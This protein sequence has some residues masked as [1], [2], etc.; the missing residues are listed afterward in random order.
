VVV[1]R[2]F[3]NVPARLKFLKSHTAESGAIKTVL[4]ALALANEKTQFRISSQGELQ[5]LWAPSTR[6]AR[7]RE[8]LEV[9]ILYET[10]GQLE[11]VHVHAVYS[12]PHTVTRTSRQIWIFVQGRWVQDR[13]IQAAIMEAYRNLLMHGEYPLAAIWVDLP[14]DRVDV[15]IH[16]AKSQVKFVDSSLVF[17][18]VRRTIRNALETAPWLK[19]VAT[20]TPVTTD[21]SGAPAPNLLTPNPTAPNSLAPNSFA[22]CPESP[23]APPSAQTTFLPARESGTH[24][25]TKSSGPRLTLEDLRQA[26][27]LRPAVVVPGSTDLARELAPEK[28]P[29]ATF[30]TSPDN[31]ILKW[32]ALQV[33]GQ[34]NLTYIVAQA[35][36]RMYLVD[37]HAA[38]ERVVFES[39]MDRWR[40]GR[41]ERQGLLLP[42][43]FDLRPEQVEALVRRAADFERMGIEMEQTGLQSVAVKSFPSLLKEA[44]LIQE[45]PKLAEDLCEIDQDLSLERMVRDLFATMACHSVVRAGQ[46]L[47]NDEMKNLLQQM[48]QFPLSGFCPHGRPVYIEQTFRQLEKQFGRTL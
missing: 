18:A 16:P 30:G 43:T 22:L 37:Q 29:L 9:P 17:R 32:G 27:I 5:N 6:L 44:A 48:D 14:A 20:A 38:H 1:D 36:D 15:N 46:A 8:I 26:Q 10:E 24:M 13:G 23:L 47:S 41:V 28:G 21:T 42:L 4:R 33:I 3:E 34:V 39:L 7:A 12:D 35:A 40:E 19:V 25:R 31:E 11:D 45:L 2:L